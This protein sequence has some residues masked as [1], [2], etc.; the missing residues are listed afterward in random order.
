MK[1]VKFLINGQKNLDNKS[2]EI[3]D[4]EIKD[5]EIKDVE[6]KQENIIK[7]IKNT[8]KPKKMVE[9]IYYFN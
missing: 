6:I 2:T 3:K 8:N 7:E 4:V 1:P 5:V 9:N